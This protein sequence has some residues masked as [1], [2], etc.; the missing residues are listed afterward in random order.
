MSSTKTY[1]SDEFSDDARSRPPRMPFIEYSAEKE[2][3]GFR[4]EAGIGQARPLS[5]TSSRSGL[6]YSLLKAECLHWGQRGHKFAPRGL[7]LR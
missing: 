1:K 5:A 7:R 4:P 3:G 2:T 6:L